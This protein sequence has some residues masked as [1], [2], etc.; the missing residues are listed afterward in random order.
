MMGAAELS[1][2]MGMIDGEVV[3]RQG[4]LLRRFNLPFRA[5]GLDVEKIFSAMSLDKKS[6]GG[7]IR[8]VLLDGVGKATTS[9]DVPPEDVREVVEGLL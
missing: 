7:A 4:D 1:R 9:R 3:K 6:T 8:W 2:R 5:E